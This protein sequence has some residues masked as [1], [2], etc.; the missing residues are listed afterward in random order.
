MCVNE[1]LCFVSTVVRELPQ[2]KNFVYPLC[3]VRI[4]DDMLITKNGYEILSISAPKTIEEIVKL[5]KME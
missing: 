5:M 3:G 4:E 1:Q 2:I